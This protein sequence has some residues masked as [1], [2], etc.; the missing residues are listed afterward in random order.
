MSL[1]T[2]E[3]TA[4]AD[5]TRVDFTEQHTF[6]DPTTPDGEVERKEREGSTRLMLNGLKAVAEDY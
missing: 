4:T 3:L 2:I 1:L 6:V 5:G